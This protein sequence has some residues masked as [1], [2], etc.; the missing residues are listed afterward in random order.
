MD[1]NNFIFNSRYWCL[2][3]SSCDFVSSVKLSSI[4]SSEELDELL[5]DV[6]DEEVDEDVDEP[7]EEDPDFTSK[8]ILCFSS[9]RDF[10]L[11]KS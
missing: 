4:S 7:D 6:L 1:C 10:T 11:K 9:R 3:W 8:A 5:E 2:A